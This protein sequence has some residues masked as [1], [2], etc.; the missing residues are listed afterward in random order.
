MIK[1]IRQANQLILQR[2]SLLV[3]FG[4]NFRFELWIED[5]VHEYRQWKIGGFNDIG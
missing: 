2:D 3:N 5:F 1:I 4:E